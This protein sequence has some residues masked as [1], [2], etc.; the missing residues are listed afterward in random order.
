MLIYLVTEFL[1][2]IWFFWRWKIGLL[3]GAFSQWVHTAAAGV[4]IMLKHL[5]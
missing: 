4:R 2:Q 3:L 5:L 1:A